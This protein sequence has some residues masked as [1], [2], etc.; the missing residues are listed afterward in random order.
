[1]TASPSLEKHSYYLEIIV[2]ATTLAELSAI[3]T[4]YTLDPVLTEGQKGVLKSR[5]EIREMQLKALYTAQP[6]VWAPAFTNQERVAVTHAQ[7]DAVAFWTAPVTPAIA[8]E[9]FAPV[10]IITVNSTANDIPLTVPSQI[11]KTSS[12]TTPAP[13][14]PVTKKIEPVAWPV[15]LPEPSEEAVPKKRTKTASKDRE[16]G[17]GCTWTKW[18]MSVTLSREVKLPIDGVQFSNNL[19]GITLTASTY[20]EAKTLI[21]EAFADFTESTKLISKAHVDKAYAQWLEDGKKVVP[22]PVPPML[23]PASK[24]AYT[25]NEERAREMIKQMANSSPAAL[26][27]AKAFTVLNPMLPTNNL[28]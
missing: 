2:E 13:V 10:E 8:D 20:E 4:E 25:T 16:D 17:T 14:I 18:T 3:R 7:D 5:Y 1:M 27:F 12:D 21:D 23:K 11:V 9:V 15:W 19:F 6:G 28:V 26:E 24:V 22:V